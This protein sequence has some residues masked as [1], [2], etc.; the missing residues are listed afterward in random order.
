[1][2]LNNLAE[3]LIQALAQELIDQGHRGTG[4]LINSLRHEIRQEGADVF[5]NIYAS[6]YAKFVANGVGASRIPYTRGSGKK[7]SKY[8][9]ALTQWVIDVLRKSP[10]SKARNIAFAIANKHK[11]EGM[12]TTNSY[13]YSKNGRRLNFAQYVINANRKFIK[14][15]ISEQFG[16]EVKTMISNVIKKNA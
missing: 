12:P 6:H 1:M 4:K 15:Q 5:L 2:N 10:E 11:K 13:R 14:Q 16:Q 8:I 7:S 9:E 3:Y